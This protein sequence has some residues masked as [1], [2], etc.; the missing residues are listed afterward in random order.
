MSHGHTG[1]PFIQN[2]FVVTD[3]FMILHDSKWW[4]LDL[5]KYMTILLN[6][7][8]NPELFL[9]LWSQIW[10]ENPIK[11]TWHS[12]WIQQMMF[13]AVLKSKYYISYKCRWRQFYLSF[14][15]NQD[16]WDGKQENEE[17][18]FG[19]QDVLTEKDMEL[20]RDIQEQALQVKS[21]FQCLSVNKI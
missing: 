4:V 20:F 8:T 21:N 2:W 19:S 3:A 18:F 13:V 5:V 16:G 17:R 15:D 12:A 1:K 10:T 9:L 14:T 7:V 6:M 11:K